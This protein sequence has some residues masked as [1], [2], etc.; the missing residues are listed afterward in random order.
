MDMG[1]QER[2]ALVTG[3]SQGIGRATARLLAREGARVVVTYRHHRDQADAVAAE[4]KSTGGEAM[5]AFFDLASDEA[6]RAAVDAILQ[7]WG[8]IDILVN[9]AVAWG[10]RPPSQAP[11]LEDL[12]TDEWRPLVRANLEGAF[13]TIQAVV[14]SMR[15]RR[16]GRIVNI[17]SGVAVDGVPG[18]SWY[19][20]AK[21]ALH[22]LTRTLSKELG[23]E[24]IL[25]NVVM[26]GFT[27]TEHN[28]QRLP[29]ALGEQMAQASPIRR[30]LPPEEVAPIIVF[31]C[32]PMNSAINGEMI[33]ASGGIT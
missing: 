28:A 20:A 17:S 15:K 11:L 18:A 10:S 26:P 9:N 32:S 1:F 24:G 6:I 23:P 7:Q 33:R 27:L 3:S 25:T 8:R 13:Q 2:V 29:P 30:L 22:G 4:I 16:W 21:A 19:E 14:P 12:P 5:V 31:L